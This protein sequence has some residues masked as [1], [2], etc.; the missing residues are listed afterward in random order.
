MI[1]DPLHIPI[2]RKEAKATKLTSLDP[3]ERAEF[4]R[5]VDEKFL[6]VG[7]LDFMDILSTGSQ[8]SSE[9]LAFLELRDVCEDIACCYFPSCHSVC[10]YVSC[11]SWKVVVV[12]G[13]CRLLWCDAVL[14]VLW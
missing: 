5:E 14:G 12:D 3:D 6:V 13:C 2:A 10:V 4:R 11:C 7:E 8:D 9:P 1:I